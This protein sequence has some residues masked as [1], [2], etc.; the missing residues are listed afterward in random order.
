MNRKLPAR[1]YPWWVRFMM[2]GSASRRALRFWS[3][4][5][6][7]TA[8]ASVLYGIAFEDDLTFGLLFAVLFLFLAM[9]HW[10]TVRWVDRHGSWS[11]HG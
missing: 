3:V 10:L 7:V 5:Y 9:A 8:I 11:S 1:E 2:L 6:V 4:L